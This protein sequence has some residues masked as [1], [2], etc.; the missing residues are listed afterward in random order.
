MKPTEQLAY[1][2]DR[3]RLAVAVYKIMLD[4]PEFFRDQD[5]L[6]WYAKV[7]LRYAE[8]DRLW[9]SPWFRFR[10]KLELLLSINLK[11][12]FAQALIEVSKMQR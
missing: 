8:V 1:A 5:P 10:L 11:N 4:Y 2:A 6:L 3:A 12:I 7:Q 9:R